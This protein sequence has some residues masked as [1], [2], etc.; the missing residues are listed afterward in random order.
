MDLEVIQESISPGGSHPMNFTPDNSNARQVGTKIGSF[1]RVVNPRLKI[2]V[3]EEENKRMSAIHH[4]SSLFTASPISYMS[5]GMNPNSFIYEFN[6]LGRGLT[7]LMTPG[8]K[9][10]HF[11]PTPG[12][13]NHASQQLKMNADPRQYTYEQPS[14]MYK[15][16][17]RNNERVNTELPLIQESSPV[18][19]FRD[20]RESG[21]ES[22]SS[23]NVLFRHSNSMPQETNPPTHFP[24]VFGF[25][26]LNTSDIGRSSRGG[27]GCSNEEYF[28][29]PRNKE[30]S[31]NNA[32]RI[33]L[34]ISGLRL[35]A[36]TPLVGTRSSNNFEWL[37]YFYQ[38]HSDRSMQDERS[39]F[40]NSKSSGE[41][42]GDLSLSIAKSPGIMKKVKEN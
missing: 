9:K 12:Q 31:G 18:Q 27:E 42:G 10:S 23:G 14:T 13:Y 6:D 19:N 39:S 16:D 24:N 15:F 1:K 41:G 33:D 37:H 2:N 21:P 7:P 26:M 25:G 36:P 22:W 40:L 29:V 5:P 20:S 38:K 3:E 35:L 34:D 4:N 8:T 11:A 28:P 32:Q 30:D 17:F